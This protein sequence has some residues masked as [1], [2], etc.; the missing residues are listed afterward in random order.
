MPTSSA[1]FVELSNV[2]RVYKTRY[3][4]VTAVSDVDLSIQAGERLALLGRSGSGKS[5]LLNLLGGLDRPTSGDLRVG[6]NFLNHMSREEMAEYRLHSV[7][8]IF[9]AF[10]LIKT[11]TALQNV[12]LPFV[13]DGQP[14]SARRKIAKEALDQV[15]LANRMRHRPD[16]LSGGEQQ[17]VAI[18]RAMVCEPQ[19]L[20]ADEPTGNLDSATAAEIMEHLTL[21][22]KSHEAAVVLVTH[23]EELASRFAQRTLRLRDGRISGESEASARE[24]S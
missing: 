1:P 13:F 8:M 5:T 6:R 11:L 17:R 10:N 14:R 3:D 4:S 16:Q 9:Q 20:L 12:E 19:L 2:S 15:G 22:S 18:A 21:F 23:D 7:G 24:A